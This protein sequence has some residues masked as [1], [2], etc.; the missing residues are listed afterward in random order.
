MKSV[1]VLVL[2]LLVLAG[3][4]A[5]ADESLS[6]TLEARKV[7][8]ANGVE[9]FESADT[10]QPNDVL[11]YRTSYRNRS[12]KTL[13]GVAATL[14]IPTGF[15][16]IPNSAGTDALASLDGKTF[17]AVPLTR[18]VKARDGR[19]EVRLVPV[20]EYRFLRWQLG[21]LPAGATST[22]T[23]RVRMQSTAPVVV[24]VAAIAVAAVAAAR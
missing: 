9:R 13:R 11:E 17:A 4:P 8:V 23:A 21:D 7:L 24:A 3:Q 10:A 19:D 6:A 18:T 14:P 16:Y 2:S 20:S 5:L 1:V 22:V 12:Q 15:E